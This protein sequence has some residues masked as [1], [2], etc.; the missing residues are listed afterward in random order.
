MRTADDAEATRAGEEDVV[1]MVV[2]DTATVAG[3]TAGRFDAIESTEET[4]E[5]EDGTGAGPAVDD[6]A[7]EDGVGVIERNRRKY[8]LDGRC[9]RGRPDEAGNGK[10]GIEDWEGAA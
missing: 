4:E 3:E 8:T 10:A 9:C 7:L 1:E 5:A 6:G 2:L